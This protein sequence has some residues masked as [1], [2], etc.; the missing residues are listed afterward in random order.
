MSPLPAIAI[1]LACVLN[2][3]TLNFTP[4]KDAAQLFS[5]MLILYFWL[6]AYSKARP[7]CGVAC[8]VIAVGAMTVGL[9]HAW[10]LLIVVA[11]TL[12]DAVTTRR[13]SPWIKSTCVPFS[14][15]ALAALG[16]AYLVMDW[17]VLRMTLAVGMRYRQMQV[18][19]ITD[20][21]YWTLVG[22]PLFLLFVG[23]M[24]FAAAAGM[25]RDVHDRPSQLGGRLLLCTVGVL[26]FTY[27][28]GNN[29]E[30][31][32]LWIPFI[33]L[34]LLSLSLRRSTFRTDSP[35]ARLTLLLLIGLQVGVTLV[36]W[37]VLD[38]RETEYRLSTGRMW[39]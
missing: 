29:N 13:L 1:A 6:F 38:V 28:F 12:W 8:G 16:L 25:R 17:N 19:I 37:A 21:F 34:L 23:P 7:T 27:F 20:P 4:G 2:P 24:F 3:S 33:P 5:V 15:G 18:P 35:R 22:F 26:L 31:P 14:L 36:H 9:I 32:R 11:A 30:T 10:V 39:D